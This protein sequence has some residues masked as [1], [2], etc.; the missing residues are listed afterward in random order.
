MQS[1]GTLLRRTGIA[2]VLLHALL[3]VAHGLAHSRLHIYM[4]N[5]QN[6]Y[7]F[8]VIIALPLVSGFLLWR[9]PH[10]IASGFSLLFFSMLG[11][12]AF[13]AYYHFI[14]PGPDNVAW[15]TEHSWTVPFQTTAVLLALTEAAGAI[16]GLLGLFASR[17]GFK[18]S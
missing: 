3:N 17:R 7:I 14:A 12:L 1:T 10:R 5:W 18:T 6:V 16:I 4:A 13:G 9:R 11:S 15:L 8:V 2:I